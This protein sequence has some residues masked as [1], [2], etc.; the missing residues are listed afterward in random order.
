MRKDTSTD[1]ETYREIMSDLM[2]PITGTDL[3]VFTLKRLYESKIVYLDNLRA[4]CFF[5]MNNGKT[6]HFTTDD[7]FLIISA[8]K[9]TRIHLRELIIVAISDHLTRR[10]VS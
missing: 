7:H 1:Y 3:D 8:I 10:K 2:S 6:S 4:K 9:Q 5:E